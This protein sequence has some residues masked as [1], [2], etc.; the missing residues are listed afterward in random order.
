MT[1]HQFS[2]PPP[3]PPPPPHLSPIIVPM[4]PNNQQAQQQPNS[5]RQQRS[6]YSEQGK[7]NY[8]KPGSP[9]MYPQL[10]EQVVNRMG[11]SLPINY[12]SSYYYQSQQL[13][14]P[15]LHV[16]P[17]YPS[18]SSVPSEGQHGPPYPSMPAMYSGAPM[19]PNTRATG[20]MIPGHSVHGAGAPYRMT[21]LDGQMYRT[22]LQYALIQPPAEMKDMPI[23]TDI[24]NQYRSTDGTPL[25]PKLAVDEVGDGFT[26]IYILYVIQNNLRRP[27]DSF[28]VP[29]SHFAIPYFGTKVLCKVLDFQGDK[30]SQTF[31]KGG[32]QN[33][34]GVDV[35]NEC[36]R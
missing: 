28:L 14:H 13:G 6:Q 30:N 20:V 21:A 15:I 25:L 31:R 18:N 27:W 33:Y 4:S 1:E 29:R 22:D 10:Q 32:N 35:S 23:P 3:P 34:D 8:R 7:Q 19:H 26:L 11:E 12:P 16:P 36:V 2:P 9:V 17:L 5:V 24:I